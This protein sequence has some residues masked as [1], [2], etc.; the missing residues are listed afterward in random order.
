MEMARGFLSVALGPRRVSRTSCASMTTVGALRFCQIKV[1]EVEM[2][3]WRE[4]LKH[5]G[6]GQP[7]RNDAGRLECRTHGAVSAV[8][9]QR[10][11]VIVS[12]G[13]I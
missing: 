11:T 5:E 4:T 9:V 7:V 12:G 13:R 8:D 1:M 6:C 10:N 2:I 3:A